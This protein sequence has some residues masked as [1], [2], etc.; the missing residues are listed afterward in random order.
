MNS[1]FEDEIIEAEN[2]E[3]IPLADR[4]RP[5]RPEDVKGQ[6]HLLAPGMPLDRFFKKG[7]FPSIVF[8]GPPGVGKTTIAQIIANSADYYFVKLSA[9]EAGVKDVRAVIANAEKL[10]KNGRRTLLF[11]DEIHRFNKNQQDALLHA[12]EKGIVT[13]IGATT[14]NPSFE[15]NSAL[16]SR[17][18]VYRLQ[19]L[20]F[21]DMNELIDD[22]LSKDPILSKYSIEIPDRGFVFE[23]CG[24][25]ARAALN[26]IELCIET[27]DLSEEKI[28]LSREIFETALQQR[29]ARYD[30]AG[31]AHY[32]TISA[33]I[34]T[35]RGSDPDAAIFWLAKMLDAGEDPKFIARRM[36]IFASEDIGNADPQALILAVNVFNAVNVIGMPEARINLAQGVTYL[37]SCPKSNASYNAINEALNDIKNG[38]PTITPLH[39]RN[40]PT[41]LMKNEGYGKDYKYPHLYE[42]AFVKEKYFAMGA[43]AKKYY[44]PNPVGKEAEFK[45][46]LDMLWGERNDK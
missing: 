23:L 35:L 15:V 32:D 43:K 38:A 45:E 25:D 40:A 12:V 29:T 41:K 27:A 46:R 8:W 2:I 7:L 36:I 39:L 42:G 13:L 34:K 16:L 20:N 44:K 6:R 26:S 22:A 17:T 33:F 10:R 30:K 18:Q 19:A 9:V 14:E 1:L 4:M 5:K 11:I 3:F 31:E 28:I 24:G 37:A 21:D